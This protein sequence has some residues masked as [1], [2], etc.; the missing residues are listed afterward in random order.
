MEQLINEIQDIIKDYRADEDLPTV[1]MTTQR[2]N[3]WVEQF[4]E[5]DREFILIEL[6]NILSKRYCS[7]EKVKTFLKAVIDKL[8]TV[9]G[10]QNP[11][12]FLT[13]LFFLT[14]NPKA[15]VKRYFYNFLPN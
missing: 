13:K 6:K 7:K 5:G 11:T 3:R 2:I 9:Y 14:F 15:K 4:D 10:Y 12:S 1:I 8:T